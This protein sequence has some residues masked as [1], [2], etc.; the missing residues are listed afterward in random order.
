MK[1]EFAGKHLEIED[2]TRSLAEGKLDRLS[3]GGRW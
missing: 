3:R 2:D 1:I